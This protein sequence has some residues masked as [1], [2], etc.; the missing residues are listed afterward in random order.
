MSNALKNRIK[1]LFQKKREV[2]PP[3][4]VEGYEQTGSYKDPDDADQVVLDQL[5]QM[6]SDLTRERHSIHYFYFPTAAGA[7][8]A[9]KDLE[10]M[11]FETRAGLMLEGEPAPRRWP[12]TAERKEVINGEVIHALRKPLTEVAE[13]F[14]GE[15]DGWEA[16]VG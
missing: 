2:Q 12:V 9:R 11:N 16:Q 4:L 3:Y 7:E 5:V 8:E 6:G 15:Y 1:K 13:R 10:K 14:G